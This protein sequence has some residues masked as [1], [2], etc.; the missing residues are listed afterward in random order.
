MADLLEKRGNGIP[1]PIGPNWVTRLLQR[2]EEIKSKFIRKFNYKRALR[3]DSRITQK[4]FQVVREITEEYR[5]LPDDTYNMD[6]IRFAIGIIATYMVVTSSERKDR[7]KLLHPGN[8]EWGTME[9]QSFR[10]RTRLIYHLPTWI[11]KNSPNGWTD[12][13]LGSYWIKEVFDRQTR[14]HTKGQ[15]RLLIMD[16]HGSHAT[17]ELDLFCIGSQIILLYMPPHSSHLLQPL[18]V[19]CFSPLKRSYGAKVENQIRCGINHV[20]KLDFLTLYSE[21]H[22]DIFAEQTIQSGFKATGLYSRILDSNNSQEHGKS[23]TAI[24]SISKSSTESYRTSFKPN[25]SISDKLFLNYEKVI[26]NN[27]LLTQENVELKAMALAFLGLDRPQDPYRTLF[28]AGQQLNLFAHSP[29]S[30][31]VLAL[32]G[33]DVV[34]V[35]GAITEVQVRS[36]RASYINALLIQSRGRPEPHACTAC[37]GGPG[38]R[39]FPECRRL[40]GHFGGACGNSTMVSG[41][42]MPLAAPHGSQLVQHL[43]LL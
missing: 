32:P 29:Q 30:R 13:E 3:E 11:V 1:N 33:Q 8:R 9:R 14:H 39:P 15:Y 16:G 35:R 28:I 27:V 21:V 4:W 10:T 26:V 6:E 38:L 23:T 12:N 17:P 34:F 24:C 19:S 37:R 40:P 43:L 36:H 20:D 41:G 42:I 25:Q 31:A 5:I 18:D 7:P 22:F 2:H